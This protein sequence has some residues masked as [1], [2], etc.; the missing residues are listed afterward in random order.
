M[1]HSN[2]SEEPLFEN[3][4]SQYTTY[5][6]LCVNDIEIQKTASS[7]GCHL[8]NFPE[9]YTLATQSVINNQSAC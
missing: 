9:S 6:E 7:S 8:T 2:H 4:T 5:K 1:S 3:T